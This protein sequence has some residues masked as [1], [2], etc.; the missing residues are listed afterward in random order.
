MRRVFEGDV[1]GFRPRISV[2][3]INKL[4][5]DTT[6]IYDLNDLCKNVVLIN[7]DSGDSFMYEKGFG[8]IVEQKIERVEKT[9]LGYEEFLTRLAEF[10]P[11]R[12]FV[13]G[14][15]TSFCT[16][17]L[18]PICNDLTVY[19]LGQGYPDILFAS[20]VIIDELE[21]GVRLRAECYKERESPKLVSCL[22]E[23]SKFILDSFSDLLLRS[24]I[25]DFDGES[26]ELWVGEAIFG[27]QESLMNVLKS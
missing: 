12:D 15:F 16:D 17:F 6:A 9:G 23:R 2:E 21:F 20:G 11:V 7:A 13:M 18:V 14:T 8:H 3:E 5:V 4:V 1:S 25:D 10:P 24:F 19:F 22:M 27:T 26:A